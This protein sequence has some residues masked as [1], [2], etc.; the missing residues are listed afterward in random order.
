MKIRDRQAAAAA[1][2]IAADVA[3]GICLNIDGTPTLFSAVSFLPARSSTSAANDRLPRE[4]SP[5]GIWNMDHSHRATR[6]SS[7]G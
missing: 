1:E 5:F 3:E 7:L 2:R 4:Q 6:L